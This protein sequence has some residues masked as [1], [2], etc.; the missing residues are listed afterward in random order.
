MRI[1]SLIEKGASIGTLRSLIKEFDMMIN[2][3]LFCI[4]KTENVQSF[5][6]LNGV[7]NLVAAMSTRVD[8]EELIRK[9]KS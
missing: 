6:A 7:K 5:K 1:C 2:I 8:A 9:K 3:K 4:D